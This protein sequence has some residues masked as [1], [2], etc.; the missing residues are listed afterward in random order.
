MGRLVAIK[1]VLSTA[2]DGMRARFGA[3]AKA[4]ARLDHPHIVPIHEA[5]VFDG[6]PYMIM[7]LIEGE[8]LKAKIGREGPL[9]ERLAAELTRALAE[10][11]AHAH[12]R[13]ILHRDLK[14]ENVLLDGSGRPLITDF[15]LAK[16]LS[17]ERERLT[18]TGQVVGSPAYMPPE[19][20]D[21]DVRAIDERSDVY[22][23]GATLYTMLTGRLPFEASGVFQI[24]ALVLADAPPVSPRVHRPDLAPDLEA[25]C[26]RAME[27]DADLRYPSA[28]ALADDLARTLAGE[29]TVARPLTARQ[30]LARRARRARVPLALLTL[31]ATALIGA[32]IYE[33]LPG[34]L[35]PIRTPPR[36]PAPPPPAER[37]RAFPGEGACRAFFVGERVVV[38]DE[39]AHL[40]VWE[41]ESEWRPRRLNLSGVV[42]AA[43]AGPA[44]LLIAR[45]DRGAHSL[46]VI[47][48]LGAPVWKTPARCRARALAASADGSVVAAALVGKDDGRVWTWDVE[49]GQKTELLPGWY[50]GDVLAVAFAPGDDR[51][52]IVQAGDRPDEFNLRTNQLIVQ[53]LNTEPDKQ[54]HHCSN[55]RALAA[56]PDGEWIAVGH[57]EG[58]VT[59]WK[60]EEPRAVRHAP[61]APQAAPRFRHQRPV[62]ALAFSPDSAR[63]YSAAE[64]EAFLLEWTRTSTAWAPARRLGLP[65]PAATLAVSSAGSVLA[66]GSGG[67]WIV[68]FR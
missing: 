6:E 4:L 42:H 7:D 36:P 41:T 30:R 63:L 62:V 52:A 65:R 5:G 10:A 56:S 66:A 38:L 25:V 48:P 31:G 3:E 33:T 34:V 1:Q 21:G 15:G 32:G 18:R 47:D 26:L 16:D 13:S 64:G 24:L 46:T 14:P 12:E 53:R 58:A 9:P 8:S 17:E 44:R 28:Q 40:T 11:L 29:P 45:E 54:E 61:L 19:Q 67:A 57:Y 51:V 50:N 39:T 22:S 23:L 60:P 68:D 43:P 20:A 59:L 2:S 55:P 37:P 49:T 35:T 27:K